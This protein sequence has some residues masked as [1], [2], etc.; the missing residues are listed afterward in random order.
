MNE[1]EPKAVVEH[2]VSV[3]IH[4]ECQCY[5][6]TRADRIERAMKK[7]KRA[8]L[9]AIIEDL[10]SSLMCLT[11]DE[12]WAKAVIDGSWPGADEIIAGTRAKRS[13]VPPSSG[14]VTKRGEANEQAIHLALS[15]LAWSN[16]ED[17]RGPRVEE[18]KLKVIKEAGAF[19]DSVG[20]VSK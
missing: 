13:T 20:S 8:D 14:S 5:I 6:C 18:F 1:S 11:L 12:N 10:H 16:E 17:R 2:W 7:G 15:V 3:P 4:H 9:I 19:V